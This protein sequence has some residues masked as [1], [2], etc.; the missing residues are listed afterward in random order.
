MQGIH[1]PDAHCA[2]GRGCC[3]MSSDAINTESEHSVCV[4][5]H[6]CVVTTAAHIKE[7]QVTGGRA[8][9]D[10]KIIW[11][12]WH[13]AHRSFVLWKTLTC[14][15][16]LLYVHGYECKCTN[17]MKAKNKCCIHMSGLFYYFCF[18]ILDNTLGFYYQNVEQFTI[19]LQHSN[20]PF[21]Q[22]ALK[23]IVYK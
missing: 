12:D 2:I 18:V 14:V 23:V 10:L 9:Q 6:Q 11:W 15:N 22:T 13:Q 21:S 3:E 17:V 5:P 20:V 19:V 7:T 4:W 1:I 16:V 8:C